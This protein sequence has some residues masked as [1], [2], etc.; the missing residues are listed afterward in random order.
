MAGASLPDSPSRSTPAAIRS[1]LADRETLRAAG[2]AVATMTAN[3]LGL[4]ITLVF[5]R[6]LGTAGYG[7][8]AALI[9][10]SLILFVPGSAL[11]VAATRMTAL[12][13]LGKG[14]ELSAT[15]RGWIRRAP[16][17]IGAVALVSVPLREPLAALVNVQEAWAAAA[18]P[19]TAALWLV[20]CVLRGVLLAGRA[21][22]AVGASLV[23]EAAGRLGAGVA[24]TAA[25]LG[26][27][28]AYLGTATALA[29]TAAV[30]GVLV[31]RRLGPPAPG[32]RPRRLRALLSGAGLPIAALGLVAC[33]QNLDVIVARHVLAEGPAGVYAAA[34]VAAKAVVWIAVGIGLWLLPEAVHRATEGR[35]ARGVLLRAFALTGLVVVPACIAYAAVP[36]LLLRTAFGP[37]YAE[38]DGILLV[39]G[40]AY[41]ALALTYLS[42]QF[43]IGLHR[44]AFLGVLAGAA[45]LEGGLLATVDTP[46]GI[47]TVVL[48]VQA[49]AA[50]AIVALALRQRARDPL[51]PAAPPATPAPAG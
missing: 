25:G 15:V 24:L 35:E 38:G 16:V 42:V 44:L 37:A 13:L 43:L 6:L 50:G 14:G 5:T 9:N 29:L 34:T 2:L 48:G 39:L 12:G 4:V 7:S 51:R 27:T 40:I 17:A 1:A 20:L 10:L 3:L 46:E 33:L 21:Y 41:G 19:V 11:Q 32:S 49:L 30:A 18:V 8:L 23:L 45:A 36:A 26:V 31:V 22:R 28:G 47:A